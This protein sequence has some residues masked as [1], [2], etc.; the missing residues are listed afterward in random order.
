M[1]T[2]QNPCNRERSEAIGVVRV[3]ALKKGLRVAVLVDDDGLISFDSRAALPDDRSIAIAGP[4]PT[5]TS[6]AA[7]GN[8]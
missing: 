2:W 6:S 5:P 7:A 3:D 1:M 4:T 8:T